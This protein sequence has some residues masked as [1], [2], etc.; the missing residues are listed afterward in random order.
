MLVREK[1][2]ANELVDLIKPKAGGRTEWQNPAYKVSLPLL[3]FF[4]YC[5]F[6]ALLPVKSLLNAPAQKK[7]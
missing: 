5:V 7:I 6:S 1:G 4:V 2:N 3:C